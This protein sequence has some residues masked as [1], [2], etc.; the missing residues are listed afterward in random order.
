MTCI[1][2]TSVNLKT[3]TF[4]LRYAGIIAD[5]PKP[6]NERVFGSWTSIEDPTKH[7]I[8]FFIEERGDGWKTE[9]ELDTD[10]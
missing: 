10:R 9:D 8:G 4:S 2:E 3:K 7:C 6:T 5:R 1:R